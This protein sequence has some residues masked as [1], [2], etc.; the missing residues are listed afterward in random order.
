MQQLTGTRD[1]PRLITS[2][3]QLKEKFLSNF[4]G[5]EADITIE[6]DFFLCQQY[7]RET[8]PDFY[9]R[10]L[11]LKAQALEVSDE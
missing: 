11:R 2:W 3:A 5:F 9:Q 8:W 4:Q 6:E 1:P 10:I 7:G